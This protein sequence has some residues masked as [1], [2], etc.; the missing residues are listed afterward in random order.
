MASGGV[1]VV[2][3]APLRATTL[4]AAVE[5]ERM[6][7]AD[8]RAS[9]YLAQRA[10]G[11][12]PRVT[13]RLAGSIRPGRTSDAAT[14]TAGAVYAGP[15]HWGWPARNIRAQPFLADALTQGEPTVAAIY[16]GEVT[17]IVHTIKGA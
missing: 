17:R 9:A 1:T 12:A 16:L 3:A 10:K 8:S 13:G 14:V 4:R 15:I 2:G 11:M 5:L 7:T 6:D